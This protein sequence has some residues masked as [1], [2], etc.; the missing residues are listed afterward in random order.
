MG[1][2]SILS[3]NSKINL[4]INYDYLNQITYFENK[5]INN[6]QKIPNNTLG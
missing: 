4:N 5:S 3:P 6:N 2:T 1:D